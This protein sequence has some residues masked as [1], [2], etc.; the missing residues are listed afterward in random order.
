MCCTRLAEYTGCKKL[1]KIRNRRTITQLCQAISYSFRCL[2]S[3]SSSVYCIPRPNSFSASF[4]SMLCTCSISVTTACSN[5]NKDTRL[6]CCMLF[7]N[8]NRTVDQSVFY[9]NFFTLAR[10]RYF[11]HG[12]YKSVCLQFIITLQLCSRHYFQHCNLYN[13]CLLEQLYIQMHTTNLGYPDVLDEVC[14]A[15][16]EGKDFTSL[17]IHTSGNVVL[18]HV[19]VECVQQHF[20][21]QP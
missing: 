19:L 4:L 3:S 6:M 7:S 2:Y 17:H 16:I 1:P 13:T 12:T 14:V 15:S 21:L 10:C 11:T 5:I 20:D 18:L 9:N 8:S